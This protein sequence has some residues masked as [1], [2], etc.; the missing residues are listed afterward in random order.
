MAWCIAGIAFVLRLVWVLVVPSKPVGDFAMYVES[1]AYL[2]AHGRLDPEFVFMP[3]Y[4]VLVAGILALGGGLWA[5]KIAGAALGALAAGAVFGITDKM[6]GRRAAWVAGIGAAVWPAGVAVASVTGTDMPTAALIAAAIWV[7]VANKSRGPWLGP[8]GFGLLMGLAAT[9]RA[10]AL[11]LA[12]FSLFFLRAAGFSWRQSLLRAGLGTATAFLVLFPWALRNHARYGEWFFTDSHGGLTA[13]VGA[14]PNT[15]G[16]YSRSLNRLFHDVTGYTLLA[17][18]H[19]KADRA[20]YELSREFAAFS[21]EYA[22]G[23]VAQKAERLLHRERFLLYWPV[24]RAG[25]LP[26]SSVKSWFWRH[27]GL[28][29]GVVD[30]FWWALWALAAVGIGFLLGR[31]AWA[32]LAFVPMQAA[33]AGIYALY[34][35]EAR[36]H[37]P[38][39]VL[40]F[41]LAGAGVCAS[42]ALLRDLWQ[43][44]AV[45][46]ATRRGAGFA[47]AG[48][49]GLFVL[50]PALRAGGRSLTERHR[51]AAHTCRIQ[52]RI[53]VCKWRSLGSGPS[54]VRG[55]YDGVGLEP[56]AKTAVARATVPLPKGEYFLHAVADLA[57][58]WSR[59]VP[60][61]GRLEVRFGDEP[62][63]VLGLSRLALA[64]RGV[65]VQAWVEHPGGELVLE[66]RASADAGQG[67]RRTRVWLSDLEVTSRPSR[68][69]PKESDSAPLQGR[70]LEGRSLERAPVRYPRPAGGS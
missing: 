51:W 69:V 49:I 28:A 31:R 8:V 50:W 42:A 53:A 7:L 14:N 17:E 4:V 63:I 37:L 22:L 47:V 3:G 21:P 11:P 44:S 38:I 43:R 5:V 46:V 36:Y 1:G 41:P 64:P 9:V 60:P 67:L 62:A 20:S 57:P 39:A 56:Q 54:A 25:V 68:P 66:L 70:S 26:E 18:P 27:R 55:I 58:R 48:L 12:G 2:L 45:P 34:F 15:D 16:R 32:A 59:A 24:Y 29:R 6:I 30:G 61:R 40:L 23:L 35:A 33:L 10:V 52:E 13:L 19:R 65:P